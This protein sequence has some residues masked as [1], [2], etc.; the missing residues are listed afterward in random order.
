VSPTE[1][2]GTKSHFFSLSSA[3]TSIPL[4]IFE[5]TFLTISSRGLSIPSNIF[6]IRPGPS[7]TLKGAKVDTTG[8]PG[9]RPA[10]SS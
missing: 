5:P 10:V 3:L 9:P 4:V 2:A 8:S 1:T 7:S 6:S